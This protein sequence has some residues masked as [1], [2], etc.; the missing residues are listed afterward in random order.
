MAETKIGRAQ[1]DADI[2]NGG[3]VFGRG[4]VS[5]TEKW[6]DAGIDEH[7][8]GM[9]HLNGNKN[10]EVA[11][12]PYTMRSG[13][14]YDFTYDNTYSVSPFGSYVNGGGGISYSVFD[15]NQTTYYNAFTIDFRI[16]NIGSNYNQHSAQAFSLLKYPNNTCV[17]LYVS[18]KNKYKF[19]MYSGGMPGGELSSVITMTE[20]ENAHIAAELY[21]GTIYLYWNGQ[22]VGSAPSSYNVVT[23]LLGGTSDGSGPIIP[24]FQE[25]RISDTARYQG[26]NFTPPTTPY[27]SG[28]SQLLGHNII[29]AEPSGF[30][31]NGTTASNAL[32]IGNSTSATGSQSLA[33]GYNINVNKPWGVALG[34]SA[35][36]SGNGGI[37]IGDTAVAN[38]GYTIA[39][40]GSSYAYATGNV[41][42]GN[43]ALTSVGS[44]AIAIGKGAKTYANN[45]VAVGN[46]A[47]VATIATD[48]VAIGPFAKANTQASYAVAIGNNAV[49]SNLSSEGIAV[50]HE[51]QAGGSAAVALGAS[52][53]AASAGAIQLGS[54]SNT[55]ASSLQFY[56]TP[57]I[58]GGYVVNDRIDK[59][60][61]A[62]TTSGYDATK[63]Q[64]LKNVSG[65]LMWVDE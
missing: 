17:T 58:S 36:V 57:I 6:S 7:T 39:L 52:A 62:S 42:I 12:S 10:N 27:V 61:L 31:S 48:A 44:Q 2:F 63:T 11:D 38:G 29:G 64:V 21:D 22:I 18:A 9:W 13:S 46:S 15:Q 41:A 51:A 47:S 60:T 40:G 5:I 25:L 43:S 49:V 55:V 28:E 34:P 56:N 8:L 54:G 24:N 32:A 14:S 16:I 3:T 19:V 35:G 23:N 50:G 30:L 45:A 1:T 37:A 4:T 33:L 26:Q 20:G 65:T 59:A 53:Y